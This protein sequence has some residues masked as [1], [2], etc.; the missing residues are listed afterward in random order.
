MKK[1]LLIIVL[2]LVG[3]GG[4]Y[5][6]IHK[7]QLVS[8]P[9]QVA[10]VTTHPDPSNATF[11][12]DDGP[13]A[14]NKGTATTNVTPNGEITQDTTLTD[15]VAYGDINNDNKSDAVALL[16]QSGSGSGVFLYVAA[17]VSGVVEY[18]GSNAVF[19]AD[20]VTP[21]TISI[22]QAGIITVTYLDRKPTD[23][24]AAE[25]TILTTKSYIYRGGQLEEK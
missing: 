1:A 4:W 18:K 6:F 10:P 25:P 7:P 9:V 2:V 24:M 8:T 3:L 23:P 20:R 5:F 19:I 14:L 22:D 15:N 11:T 21:K 12:F 13:I 17:Y 16:V